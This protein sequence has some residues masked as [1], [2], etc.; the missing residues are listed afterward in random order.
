MREKAFAKQHSK[1]EE[2]L[3]FGAKPLPPLSVGGHSGGPGKWTT[4]GT[5]VEGLPHSSYM[6]IIHGSRA[7]T[8][9]NRKFLQKITPFHPMIPT[10]PDEVLLRPVYHDE[11]LP[12]PPQQPLPVGDAHV[13]GHG[14][15]LPGPHSEPV[16]S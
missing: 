15:D 11:D 12:A 16:G 14:E 10:S 9:R 1:M 2:R 7:P 3:N 5:I 13:H 4:T 6:V 8:Q